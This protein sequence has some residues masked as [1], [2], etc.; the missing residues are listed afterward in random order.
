MTLVHRCLP[1]TCELAAAQLWRRHVQSFVCL[2]FFFED[3]DLP[4]TGDIPISWVAILDKENDENPL[5]SGEL[6]FFRQTP[7][8]CAILRMKPIDVISQLLVIA[9]FP[10]IP[11]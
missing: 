1:E 10:G 11:N 6:F 3:L 8:G 7:S 4:E 9:G 2:D 5:N